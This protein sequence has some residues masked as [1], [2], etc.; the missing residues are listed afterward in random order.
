M[1]FV[2]KGKLQQY[3]EAPLKD[4]LVKALERNDTSILN[5]F[6]ELENK[7]GCCG[8]Y[9]ITDYG[10]DHGTPDSK[11]CTKHPNLGCSQAII[12][13]FNKH[14]PIIGG[15]LGGIL[16]VELFALLGAC[17]LARASKEDSSYS[18]GPP[19]KRYIMRR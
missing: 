13:W 12:D 17:L 4:V 7:I 18:T 5:A 19:D 2:F 8:V 15:I 3:F 9:N 10:E 11:G 14:L 1:A 16:A 6:K